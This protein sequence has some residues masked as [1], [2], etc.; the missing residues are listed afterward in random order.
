MY[1]FS[2][3]NQKS[4][5]KLFQVTGVVFLWTSIMP[6][7]HEHIQGLLITHLQ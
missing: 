5:T 4:P 1:I 7:C 3:P 6:L 2:S